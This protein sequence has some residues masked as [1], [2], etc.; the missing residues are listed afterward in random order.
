MSGYE[1]DDRYDDDYVYRGNGYAYDG[2]D[3]YYEY[4]GYGYPYAPGWGSPSTLVTQNRTV[5]TNNAAVFSSLTTP[6]V[7]SSLWQ[8]VFPGAN[9]QTIET[10]YRINVANGRAI[11][12][13][14]V[15]AS[16]EKAVTTAANEQW[17]P[18]NNRVAQIERG[19]EQVALSLWRDDNGNGIFQERFSLKVATNQGMATGALGWGSYPQLISG[20]W[21]AVQSTPNGL[22]G[23]NFTIW[24]DDNRDGLWTKI[25][26]GSSQDEF[27]LGNGLIDLV[28][29][30][31]AGAFY[32][33]SSL[34]G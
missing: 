13:A 18:W 33:A 25:A 9:T 4:R 8:S 34:V 12:V 23:V 5:A 21:W 15:T 10:G 16:G 20:T 29:L 17:L 31:G 3:D 2:W 26:E 22:G 24:R 14:E 1:W 30:V 27:L 11:P 7:W 28:G 6:G 19:Q 32:P